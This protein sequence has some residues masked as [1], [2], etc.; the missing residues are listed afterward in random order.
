M[1]KYQIVRFMQGGHWIKRHGEWRCVVHTVYRRCVMNPK[2]QM[3]QDSED[4]TSA[5]HCAL[6]ESGWFMIAASFVAGL[7]FYASGMPL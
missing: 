3:L 6:R 7:F 2:E 1:N 4:W 5:K